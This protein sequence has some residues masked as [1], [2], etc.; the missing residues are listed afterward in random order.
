MTMSFLQLRLAINL[1]ASILCFSVAPTVS[2]QQSPAECEDKVTIAFLL[3]ARWQEAQ[4]HLTEQLT[5]NIATGASPLARV[6]VETLL[7]GVFGQLERFP[8]AVGMLDKTVVYAAAELGANHWAT[9]D[10]RFNLAALHAK[11]GKYDMAIPVYRSLLPQYEQR[12]GA[13]SFRVSSIL[14]NISTS[15]H[16]LGNFADALPIDI[17]ALQIVSG[18]QPGAGSCI[19][20]AN[21]KGIQGRA[22]QHVAASLYRVGRA[23][24]ALPHALKGIDFQKETKGANHPET[25]DAQLTYASVLIALNRS[26]E[27][28]VLQA[29]VMQAARQVLGATHVL[30]RKAMGD[31]A[32]SSRTTE[33]L[34]DA[35]DID[36]KRLSVMKEKLGPDHPDIYL[37]TINLVEKHIR[38]NQLQEAFELAEAGVTAMIGRS[39]TLAFDDRTLDAWIKAQ[40]RL[41]NVYLFLLGRA[42]RHFDGFLVTEFLKHRK[43][44]M[45]LDNQAFPTTDPVL[46]L[47]IKASSRKLSL[48]DQRIALERSLGQVTTAASGERSQEFLNW[49]RLRDQPGY[50]LPSAKAMPDWTKRLLDQDETV[51]SYRFFGKLLYAYAVD[52]TRTHVFT[53]DQQDRVRP[54]IEAYRLGMRHL[55]INAGKPNEAPPV[56]RLLNGAYRYDAQRPAPDA[57]AVS[58]I[59]EILVSLSKILLTDVLPK[60]GQQKRLLISIDENLGHVPF[61]SLPVEGGLLGDRYTVGMLPSFALYGTLA[62]RQASYASIQRQPLLAVGGA[63]YS[64]FKTISPLIT[65]QRERQVTTTAMDLKVMWQSVKRDR[66]LLPLALLQ[67]STGQSDLPGSLAEVNAIATAFDAGTKQKTLLLTEE[68]ASEDSINKLAVSGELERFKILH[69]STHGYLSDDEAALS[70]IVLNQVNRVNGTDGYLTSAELSTMK[71]QSDLVVVSACDSGAS[72]RASG[73]GATGLSFALFQAGTISSILTLWPVPDQDSR[74]FM[75]RFYTELKLGSSTPLALQKTKAWARINKIS[76]HVTQGFVMWGI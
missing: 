13:N 9:M 44:S 65:V 20:P 51:V 73:D 40:S 53:V 57:Q 28:R 72:E 18:L 38:L 52:A 3:Q 63:Q 64:R 46:H 49:K 70:A 36:K 55:A 16:W 22:H 48:L 76:S 1:A 39:D 11:Q 47:A 60:L 23:Q 4:Q 7:A 43:L 61:D 75:E 41:T 68:D 45:A 74:K 25:L 34:K 67:F 33:D 12:Y 29:E 62:A 19:S 24:E 2:A 15:L 69:F 59:N 21:C 37:T 30:T 54:S 14:R 66:S 50:T 10:A 31:Y 32:A 17:R 6:C 8:E 5:K 27:A 35:I 26:D 56:W 58:N 42:N 71:L